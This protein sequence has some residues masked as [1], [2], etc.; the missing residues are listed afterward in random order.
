MAS[1]LAQVAVKGR[2]V[3]VHGALEAGKVAGEAAHA[4]HGR[5]AGAGALGTAHTHAQ[6]LH[7]G[8]VV[9]RASTEFSRTRAAA[10][11]RKQCARK[12]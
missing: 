7:L 3:V 12:R 4:A 10:A 8:E 1:A 11:A 5:A 6:R 2:A 9:E